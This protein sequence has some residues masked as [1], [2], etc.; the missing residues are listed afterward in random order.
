MIKQIA[1][2]IVFLACGFALGG[3]LDQP[4]P[5]VAARKAPAPDYQLA[6]PPG[7]PPSNIRAICFNEADLN[8]FRV[9]QLKEQLTVGTL[10]CQAAG[11]RRLYEGHYTNFLNKFSG[12]L[13]QNG[14]ELQGVTA[15]KRRNM[16]QLVTEMANRTAQRAPTD[17]EFCARQLRTFEW[18][19]SGQVTS[20]R[21]VPAPYD[22]GPDMSVYPCPAQ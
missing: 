17:P 9:R 1:Q 18:A 19:L 22:L 11:G 6:V 14:R 8:T 10:Q 16:D 3:C 13:S 12:E 15:R 2:A 21:Q 4:K 5:Q 7:P 20:M